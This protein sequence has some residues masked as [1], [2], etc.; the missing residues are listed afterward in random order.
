[1]HFKIK[2]EK[3]TLLGGDKKWDAQRG[4]QMLTQHMLVPVLQTHLHICLCFAF[5]YFRPE[6]TFLIAIDYLFDRKLPLLLYFYQFV[7]DI[8]SNTS[9]SSAT[10]DNRT[11]E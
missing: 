8:F 5:T 1:M 4:D 10:S 11:K 3:I 9:F 2:A 6:L 7:A